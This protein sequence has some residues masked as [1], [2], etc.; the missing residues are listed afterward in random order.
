MNWRLASTKSAGIV[1]QNI[2]AAFG[3]DNRFDHRVYVVFS[4]NI[5]HQGLNSGTLETFQGLTSTCRGVDYATSGRKLS[6]SV[7]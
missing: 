4:E 2:D 5:Q 3:V 7:K 6:A 1:D